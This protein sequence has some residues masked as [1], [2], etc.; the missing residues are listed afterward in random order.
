MNSFFY[1]SLVF[2]LL[3]FTS[4]GQNKLLD[5]LSN[6]LENLEYKTDTN[7]INLHYDILSELINIGKY[8]EAKKEIK[9]ALDLSEKLKYTIGALKVKYARANIHYLNSENEEALAIFKEIETE[10]KS[11]KFSQKQSDNHMGPIY[12]TMG[13]IFDQKTEYGKALEYYTK[14][15]VIEK[16]LGNLQN[17]GANLGSIANIYEK[18]NDL[19]EAIEYHE[20]AIEV[21]KKLNS[22]YSLGLSYYNLAIVYKKKESYQKSI[23]LLYKSK[24]Y[25]EEANDLIGVA[26]CSHTLGNIYIDIHLNSTEPTENKINLDKIKL[27]K[28]QLLEKAYQSELEAIEILESINEKHYI[29]H[30]YLGMGTVLGNQKKYNEAEAYYKKAYE[31]SKDKDIVA[32]KKA[33]LGLYEVNKRAKKFESALNWHEKYIKINDSINSKEKQKEIGK[34]QAELTFI[35]TKEI[36]DLKHKTEIEKLNL[37]NEKKEII[38][39]NEQRKQQYIIWTIAIG[40]LLIG[41]F[42]IIVIRRWR[43]S[44]RQNEVIEKQKE[45]IE[46]EKQATEDSINYAKNIQKAAFPTINEVKQVIPNNFILFKPKDIVSGDFYWASTLGNKKIIALA[47]CTGHGVPG[48]FMTLISL[49]ILNQIIAEGISSTKEIL[50]QL[51]FRLQKRLSKTSKHGLDIAICLIENEK[52]TFSGVHIPIY[53]V[54]NGNLVE[55]KGQKFQLGSND[56]TVFQQHEIIT[57]PND[58][59][60]ISTDGFPDQKGGVKGK[61]YYYPTLRNKLLSIGN[62]KLEEQEKEL[63]IEFENWKGKQEQFDDVSIIGFKI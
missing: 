34:R 2:L 52:L 28:K 31:K 39:K 36:A 38:A 21:K 4:Y 7:A 12:S 61:K 1:A 55:I 15:L 60:Y 42:L 6:D 58:L 49:S 50:E 37:V 56:S 53:H 51:H 24:G 23:D 54:R 35:K 63:A 11:K 19:D 3:T 43:I 16:A 33:F 44:K 27:S 13:N 5:S 29:P 45:F 48:A 8:E 18:T 26:L 17:H 22:P 32:E 59:F 20:K 46:K 14:A 41:L 9:I 62:L 30:V 57:Q 25:A 40:F 47:D 10:I